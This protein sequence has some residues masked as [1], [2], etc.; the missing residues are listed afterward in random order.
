MV[1]C[2]YLIG[3]KRTL[4]VS[5]RVDGDGCGSTI[6]A[7]NCSEPIAVHKLYSDGGINI[8]LFVKPTSQRAGRQEKMETMHMVTRRVLD[9]LYEPS[10]NGF[11]SRSQDGHEWNVSPIIGY[12]CSDNPEGK[13]ASAVQHAT[14]V[15]C[16]WIRCVK[17]SEE[18]DTLLQ[19]PPRAIFQTTS[20]RRRFQIIFDEMRKTSITTTGKYC[21]TEDVQDILNS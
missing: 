19:G 9:P 20:A 5:L 17:R 3:N 13:D 21:W 8:Y 10:L 2:R 4:V 18:L 6:C 16:P 1:H 15:K 7:E 12:Y 14:K 11:R